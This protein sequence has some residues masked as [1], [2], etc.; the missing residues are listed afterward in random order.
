MESKAKK[1]VQKGTHRTYLE[2]TANIFGVKHTKDSLIPFKLHHVSETDFILAR[3]QGCKG[4]WIS[5]AYTPPFPD[6]EVKTKMSLVQVTGPRPE[7]QPS[8]I[9]NQN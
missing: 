6:E 3:F 4:P 2:V 1:K 5:P 8:K 7:L 9:H